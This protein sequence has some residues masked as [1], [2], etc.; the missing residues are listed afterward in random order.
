MIQNN[1]KNDKKYLTF[2][3]VPVLLIGFNR[4]KLIKARVNELSLMPIKKLYISLDGG[5][6]ENY[7]QMLKVMKWSQAKLKHIEYLKIYMQEK[8]LGMVKHITST[9]TMLL[10]KHSHLVIIEDDI[11]LAENFFENM[12]RGLNHQIKTGNFGI[13]GGF[14]AL[15]LSKFRFYENKWRESNYCA[16][17]GWGCSAE[18]WKHYSNTL[19][20]KKFTTDLAESKSWSN[21]SKFQQQTWRG[22]FYKTIKNPKFTWDIQLQYLSFTRDFINLYPTST[23]TR[24]TGY[25]DQRSTNT[26]NAKPNWM[27]M[28]KPDNRIVSNKKIFCITKKFFQMIDANIFMS[29]TKFMHWFKHKK[30]YRVPSITHTHKNLKK[31]TK[32]PLDFVE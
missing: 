30:K 26:K 1:V 10:K 8:N 27:T 17:W 28:V 12:V 29:D 7:N 24:N 9:I 21:L 13:V 31:K 22:R 16:I 2:S 15:N 14:S 25:S 23:L 11:S 18:V 32:M 19:D 20:E 6:D 5:S 3:D 4:P